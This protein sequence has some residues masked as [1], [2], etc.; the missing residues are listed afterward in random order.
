[1]CGSGTLAIEAALLASGRRPGLFREA[2]AFQHLRGY[3]A[4]VVRAEME[5]LR[6]AIVAKPTA[7]IIASDHDPAAVEATR[8][9][10]A[11][12]GVDSLIQLETCDFAATTVPADGG[13][14]VMFNPEY[15]E[16][17]GEESELVATYAAIGNFLKHRCHGYRGYVFTGNPDLAK[18]IGLRPKRRIEF[19]SARLECRLFEFELYAGSRKASKQVAPSGPDSTLE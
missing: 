15:G 3:D 5:K 13:G 11:A 17:L 4:T 19:H 12:A 16:R 9:N 18:R 8:K 6:Q 10:A 2:W 14:V 1:M 7:T